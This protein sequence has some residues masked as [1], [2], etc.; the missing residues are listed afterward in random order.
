MKNILITIILLTIC[1]KANCQL[2]LDSTKFAHYNRDTA[3]YFNAIFEQNKGLY[4]NQSIAKLVD[5][6][7]LPIKNVISFGNS[8]IKIG[9]CSQ[10][11]IIF[12][13]EDIYDKIINNQLGSFYALNIVFKE[14]VF[15][16]KVLEIE[17]RNSLK[18]H[19]ELKDLFAPRIVEKFSFDRINFY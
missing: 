18:W 17:M 15:Y 1:A 11:S 10:I 6:V 4:I 2:N 19:G 14:Q 7:D 12:C 16:P 13:N 3:R 5:Y 9:S 8:K